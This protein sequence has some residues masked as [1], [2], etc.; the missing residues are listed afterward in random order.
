MPRTL[1][2]SRAVMARNIDRLVAREVAKVSPY[3]VAVRQDRRKAMR[4]LTAR[5]VAAMLGVSCSK[6]IAR[7]ITAGWLKGRKGQRVGLDLMW[8]VDEDAVQTFLADPAHWH[9]WTPER[10]ADA[11]LRAWAMEI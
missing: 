9:R 4:P 11:G 1:A 8:V 2:E 3:A 10:I 7:W 6:T 5:K